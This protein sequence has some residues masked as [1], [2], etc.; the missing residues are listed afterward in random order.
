MIRAASTAEKA[1]LYFEQMQHF[2]FTPSLI[3]YCSLMRNCIRDQR[4]DLYPRIFTLFHQLVSFGFTPNTHVINTLLHAACKFSDLQTALLLWSYIDTYYSHLRDCGSY[5]ILLRTVGGTMYDERA[6]HC[7]SVYTVDRQYFGGTVTDTILSDSINTFWKL[8]AVGASST[9][10]STSLLRL[11]R[12]A[13]IMLAENLFTHYLEQNTTL[14]TRLTLDS[15]IRRGVLDNMLQPRHGVSLPIIAASNVQEPSPMLLA[16]LVGVYTGAAVGILMQDRNRTG[17]SSSPPLTAALKQQLLHSSWE[18]VH[19]LRERFPH[20][21]R[22]TE[23]M[24]AYIFSMYGA[25]DRLEDSISHYVY[26]TQELGLKPTNKTFGT[27]CRWIVRNCHLG[28]ARRMVA[29]MRRHNYAVPADFAARIQRIERAQS[30]LSAPATSTY[31]LPV[32]D[33][34]DAGGFT[35]VG[36]SNL[37]SHILYSGKR[38]SRRIPP[39]HKN[40]STSFRKW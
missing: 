8:S 10:T 35:A 22:I 37:P 3:T 18:K 32:G 21:F 24:Y 20:S 17:V 19:A 36:A 26:L 6:S 9:T 15:R 38:T 29:E 13:R 12:A 34:D 2:H 7:G 14:G 39:T 1:F 31:P 4:V 25:A 27:Y 11:D 23:H 5:E 33:G 30:A 16:E 40:N 28:V